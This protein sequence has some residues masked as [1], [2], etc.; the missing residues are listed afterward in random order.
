MQFVHPV[1]NEPMV[2]NYN[3]NPGNGLHKISYENTIYL[4][5][6]VNIKT[7]C[8]AIVCAKAVALLSVFGVRVS[9]T[10]H[11]VYVHTIFS[12]V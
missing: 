11:L 9:V 10:F 2:S 6:I 7:F 4:K 3:Y 1:N 12:S 8:F 5:N